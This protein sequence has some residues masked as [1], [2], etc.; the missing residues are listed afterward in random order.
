MVLSGLYK[1]NIVIPRRRCNIAFTISNGTPA[2]RLLILWHPKMIL[3]PLFHH[4]HVLVLK[5]GRGWTRPVLLILSTKLHAW[6]RLTGKVVIRPTRSRHSKI[7]LVL[8]NLD[9][10]LKDVYIGARTE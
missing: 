3:P 5:H 6:G 10:E 2:H 7:A 1:D 8:S 4:G 9:R